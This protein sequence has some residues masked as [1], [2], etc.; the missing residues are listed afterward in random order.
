MVHTIVKLQLSITLSFIARAFKVLGGVLGGS[1]SVYVDALTPIANT[2]SIAFI[3]TFYK[4]S[5]EPFVPR[6]SSLLVHIYSLHLGTFS[7][8]TLSL[9]ALLPLEWGHWALGLTARA[10]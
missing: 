9:V 1:K 2:M 10:P 5:L 8:P 7:S 3:Y 4:K 6:C